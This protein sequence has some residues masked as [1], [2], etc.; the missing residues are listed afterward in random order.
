MVD[1]SI[2]ILS[3]NVRELLLA[4]LKSIFEQTKDLTFEVIVVDNCSK[5]GSLEAVR[6]QFPQ[7]KTIAN[8]F[9]WG[10]S[11]GN[12]I[13]MLQAHG[14]AVI[15]LNSD[16]ELRKNIFKELYEAL[17]SDVRLGAVGPRL[18]YP[19]GRVQHY[20]ARRRQSL[21]QTLRL[22]YIPF[23]RAP[24]LFLLEPLAYEGLY[25]TQGLSGAAM[26]VKREV[27]ERVGGLDEG[28]WA[29]CEDADW[30]ERIA[31]AGY[32]LACLT[33]VDLIHYH[34]QGL[35]QVELRRRLEAVRSEIRYFTKYGTA[36]GRIFYRVALSVNCILRIVT[37]DL[38]RWLGGNRQR[39]AV[40]FAVLVC[41]LSHHVSTEEARTQEP[42]RLVGLQPAGHQKLDRLTSAPPQS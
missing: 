35:K 25:A 5:D 8:S 6:K 30:S 1:L 13:G 14:R 24:Q 3:F 39:L 10:F 40:D 2:I 12:N 37:L 42:L 19:D 4:C 29:Y 7:V 18:I 26:M 27:L 41:V 21:F 38:I 16:T 9:N 31:G 34:G 20:C 22:Y 32:V 17:F 11:K 15:I 33:S 36:A 28:F 23:F